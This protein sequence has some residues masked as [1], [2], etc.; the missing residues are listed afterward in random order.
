ML[1]TLRRSKPGLIAA[2]MYLLAFL[3]GLAWVFIAPTL[4]PGESGETG[5]LLLPFLL[6]WIAIVPAGAL[7][8][9]GAIGIV[10]LNTLC[11]YL[12]FGGLRVAKRP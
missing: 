3:T 2:S 1:F 12:L 5:I 8:F 7:G 10:G 9:W 6:P 4:N 11:V